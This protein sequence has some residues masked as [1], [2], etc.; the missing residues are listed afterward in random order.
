MSEWSIDFTTDAEDDLG[1]LDH[2]N[3][4]RI[5]TKLEWLARNFDSI[6]PLP[7]TGPWQGFFKLRV[8]DLRIIYKAAYTKLLLTVYVIDRRDKVYK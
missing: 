5:I 1:K 8:G 3:R 6:T 4:K 2:Q 7:L